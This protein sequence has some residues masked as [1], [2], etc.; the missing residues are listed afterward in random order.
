MRLKDNIFDSLI[1]WDV[2]NFDEI[3]HTIPQ[4]Y[5]TNLLR[6]RGGKKIKLNGQHLHIICVVWMGS[7]P[8]P[9]EKYFSTEYHGHKRGDRDWL[10]S[11]L[12]NGMKMWLP[13]LLPAQVGMFGF[14]Q[15][16]S[17]AFRLDL[18]KYIKLFGLD[19]LSQVKPL[20]IHNTTWVLYSSENSMPESDILGEIDNDVYHAFLVTRENAQYLYISF[21]NTDWLEEHEG[22]QIEIFGEFLTIKIHE[23][24]PYYVYVNHARGSQLLLI[25]SVN[26]NIIDISTGSL[27]RPVP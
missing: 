10:I 14:C 24:G 15:S 9:I 26:K 27:G 1:D 11:N 17:S 6:K 7:E 13:D 19:R 20:V 5:R 3:A 22:N 16:E 2:C 23:C 4:S 25:R 18:E 12:D 8:C 21:N